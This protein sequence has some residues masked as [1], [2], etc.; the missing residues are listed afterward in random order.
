MRNRYEFNLAIPVRSWASTLAS[1]GVSWPYSFR[2]CLPGSAMSTRLDSFPTF[3]GRLFVGPRL[4]RAVLSVVD[5]ALGSG[6]CGTLPCRVAPLAFS[7]AHVQSSS[8]SPLD[9]HTAVITLHFL[10]S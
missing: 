1:F 4:A 9:N 2:V 10:L 3:S 8:S 5:R 6:L 7:L